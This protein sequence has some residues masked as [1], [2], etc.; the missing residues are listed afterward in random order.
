[1]ISKAC[2][3]P[4]SPSSPNNSRSH[5]NYN[6]FVFRLIK[7]LFIGWQFTVPAMTLKLF[8]GNLTHWIAISWKYSILYTILHLDYFCLKCD[9]G[10]SRFWVD[11]LPYDPEFRP[12]SCNVR[13]YKERILLVSL[14]ARERP[15]EPA[16]VWVEASRIGH[17]AVAPTWICL[18]GCLVNKGCCLPVL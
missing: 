4:F 5:S 15:E 7:F 16:A 13:H 3:C 10:S 8:V 2:E 11:N 18:A 1:M 12:S 6:I 14:V 17:Q 9:T